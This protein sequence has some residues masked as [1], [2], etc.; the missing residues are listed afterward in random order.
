MFLLCLLLL[1]HN[2]WLPSR[3]SLLLS[4]SV[5]MSLLLSDSAWLRLH[6]TRV[7]SV[8]V[9]Q[10]PCKLGMIKYTFE[11]FLNWIEWL[12]VLALQLCNDVLFCLYIQ[13]F[14]STVF[15]LA[16]TT[17]FSK[18]FVGKLLILLLFVMFEMFLVW[19][20]AVFWKSSL[21]I[22]QVWLLVHSIS[23]AIVC[24][25]AGI[26]CVRICCNWTSRTRRTWEA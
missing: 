12:Y 20:F 24:I 18:I 9:R 19:F 22:L 5:C 8:M 25:T 4:V 2:P 15:A 6:G 1:I 3:M 7:S 21:Y 14:I 10:K 11:W 23:K 26:W 17:C 16:Y 13:R